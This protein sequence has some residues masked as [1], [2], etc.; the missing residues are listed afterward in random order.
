MFKK[1][2]KITLN[3]VENAKKF[4]NTVTYSECKV[5]LC[6]DGWVINGKSLLG[7]FS[8]DLSIPVECVVESES[9]EML[10]NLID[11]L[12]DLNIITE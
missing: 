4:C 9:E 8:L 5:S 7:I 3:E 1:V 6:R 11:S 12:K 2:F 10:N